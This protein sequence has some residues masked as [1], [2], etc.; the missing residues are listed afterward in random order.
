MLRGS[1]LSKFKNSSPAIIS[2][3]VRPEYNVRVRFP[4]RRHKDFNE[5]RLDYK[6]LLKEYRAKNISEHWERQTQVE[7]QFIGNSWLLGI[8][9]REMGKTT[10]RKIQT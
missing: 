7:N 8:F 6:K 2:L 3:T 4:Q 10:G 1:L 5:A 9:F